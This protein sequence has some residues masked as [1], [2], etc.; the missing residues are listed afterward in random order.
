MVLIFPGKNALSIQE[1]VDKSK[2]NRSV[3]GIASL[4]DSMTQKAFAHILFLFT[5]LVERKRSAQNQLL[6]KLI[7]V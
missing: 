1:Y 6:K 5:V 2:N 7:L 3:L 4:F